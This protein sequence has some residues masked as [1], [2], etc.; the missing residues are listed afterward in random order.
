[1]HSLYL[2]HNST[3]P[4]DSRVADS[5]L[6]CYRAGYANPASQHAAGRR[7]RRVLEDARESIAEILG[8]APPD[9]V[10]FT[11]GGTESNNLAIRGLPASAGRI[12]VS[13]IEHPSADAAALHLR[14]RGCDVR[15]LP[16]DQGGRLD[17]ARAEEW[18]CADDVR[19]VTVM[20]G[21]NETGVLQPVREVAALCARHGVP[22][23]TDAVQVVGKLPV[24]FRELGVTALSLSAH[25]FHGPRGIGA[26]IL[27]GDANLQPL[28]WGGFQQAGLRPGTESV[29]LAVG[30]RTALQL[31][32]QEAEQRANR[33][34]RLRDRLETVLV[35]APLRVVVNG[36]E[37]RLPHTTNVSFPGLDRQALLMALD[38]AGVHCSTGS[39]CAS[40]S[41]EPSPVLLAMRCPPDVV[42]GSLRISLGAQTTATDV[43]QAADRILSVAQRLGH[44]AQSRNSPG[45]P[46]G[47]V[48]KPL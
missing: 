9:R 17:V 27:R 33:M 18:I 29:A 6:E 32:Q 36:L 39:A 47:P 3:T 28:L 21:N 13:S 48:P 34:R 31:W 24:D 37:P 12:L 26:L 14:S 45:P 1:M 23:H 8:A 30:M 20:L 2:D 38:Q 46:R 35:N 41:S 16:V 10:I 43:D 5:M 44:Q 7:A 15:H 19:L 40:G 11:S 25:K 4:I 22:M 42:A